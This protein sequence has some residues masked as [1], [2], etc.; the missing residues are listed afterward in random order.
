[1][2]I[3]ELWG[4]IYYLL[5]NKKL[6]K[7]LYYFHDFFSAENTVTDVIC[8]HMLEAFC[9]TQLDEID[10]PVIM[11]QQDGAPPHFSNVL[12]DALDDKFADK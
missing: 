6:I 5:K 7:Y 4:F 12:R 8:L 11:F 1:L 2:A 3:K 10:N 9:F